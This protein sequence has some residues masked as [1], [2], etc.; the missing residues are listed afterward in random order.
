MGALG[1]TPYLGAGC[2]LGVPE[3]SMDSAQQGRPRLESHWSL[4]GSMFFWLM[5]TPYTHRPGHVG[6]VV[7]PEA[8]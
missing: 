7:S 5:R 3:I 6:F 2:G 4:C 1:Y 8:S